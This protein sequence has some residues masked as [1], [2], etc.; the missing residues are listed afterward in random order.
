MNNV[1]N[2]I[3]QFI[4]ALEPLIGPQGFNVNTKIEL[5]WQTILNLAAAAGLITLI[6]LFT[7][8]GFNTGKEAYAKSNSVGK[9]MIVAVVVIIFAA[10]GFAFVVGGQVKTQN[11]QQNG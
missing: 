2:K 10:I 4:A 5:G 11:T 3:E 6:V 1:L 7:I 9:I 8:L